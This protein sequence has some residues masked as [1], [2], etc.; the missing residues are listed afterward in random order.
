VEALF[1]FLPLGLA[2]LKVPAEI[3]VVGGLT[4]L[5]LRGVKESCRC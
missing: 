4:A 3:I 5:N 1:S 2:A